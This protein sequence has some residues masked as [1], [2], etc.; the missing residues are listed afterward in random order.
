MDNIFEISNSVRRCKS[1]EE[2]RKKIHLNNEQEL[3]SEWEVDHEMCAFWLLLV[4]PN[5]LA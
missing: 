5:R 2:L 3:K 1:Q 4:S